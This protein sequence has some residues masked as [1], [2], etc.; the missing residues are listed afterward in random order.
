MPESA[1]ISHLVYIVDHRIS[2]RQLR[3]MKIIHVMNE[4]QH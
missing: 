1:T 3:V 4:D 2:H